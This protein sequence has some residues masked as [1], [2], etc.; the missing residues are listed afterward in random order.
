MYKIISYDSKNKLL[1][2]FSIILLQ[3]SPG[4]IKYLE[5]KVRITTQCKYIHIKTRMFTNK[6][7]S[8]Q[9]IHSNSYKHHSFF[10]LY[11]YVEFYNT[12]IYFPIIFLYIQREKKNHNQTDIS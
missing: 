1:L 9:H 5:R 4:A 11:V 10:R 8:R 6:F 3:L 12:F 2:N 7:F